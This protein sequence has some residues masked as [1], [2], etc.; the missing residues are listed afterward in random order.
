MTII[1]DVVSKLPEAVE[2]EYLN[3][4]TKI[5]LK[6]WG[7]EFWIANKS[8]YCGKLLIFD[9]NKRC[10]WHFHRLKDETFCVQDGQFKITYGWSDDLNEA[11]NITLNKGDTFYVQRG[12]RHSMLALTNQAILVEISTEHFDEDSYRVIPGD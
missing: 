9:F 1:N 5:V 6:G 12:L 4:N 10:S 3:K 8:D 2:C 11:Q 7:K